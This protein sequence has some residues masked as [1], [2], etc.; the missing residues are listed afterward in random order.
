MSFLSSSYIIFCCISFMN[1]KTN[2]YYIYMHNTEVAYVLQTPK[3]MKHLHC[4]LFIYFLNLLFLLAVL[5]VNFVCAF[6]RWIYDW[7]NLESNR[8]NETTTKKKN[9]TYLIS[10]KIKYEQKKKKK[11]LNKCND[12]CWR[13][14]FQP[15]DVLY[16]IHT[17]YFTA[18]S[19]YSYYRC[20]TFDI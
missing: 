10:L 20:S 1:A 7:K 9:K 14:P 4:I 12:S 3:P 5:Q 15:H 8:R 2:Y 13:R 6:F 16:Y 19:F 11:K 18:I 17:T